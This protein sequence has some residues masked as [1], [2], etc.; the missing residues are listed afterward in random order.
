MAEN[1]PGTQGS[2]EGSGAPSLASLIHRTDLWVTAVLLAFCGTA[3]YLTTTFEE[4]SLLF[5][6]NIPPAWFPRLLLWSIAILALTLPFEHM[7][8]RGGRERLD[9]DR[10]DRVAPITLFTAGLLII[11]VVS[12]EIFGLAL[13]T[14][15]VCAALP[16]LW[17]ER[18]ARVLI[19]FALL[20]PATIVLLFSQLLKIYFEPGL[21]GISVG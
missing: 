16:L 20:F 12:V 19:P 15:F 18:R 17:G 5:Q 21:L 6:G 8:V 3:Y 11:V 2:G 10:G 9:E 7:F 13:A 4:M 1:E 14:V